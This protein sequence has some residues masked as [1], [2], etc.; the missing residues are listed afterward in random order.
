MDGLE[1]RLKQGSQAQETQA[2]RRVIKNARATLAFA[3]ALLGLFG[4]GQIARAQDFGPG[5][6]KVQNVQIN[7]SFAHSLIIHWDAPVNS[8]LPGINAY[9][10]GWASGGSALQ[11]KLVTVSG[12]GNGGIFQIQPLIQNQVYT[13]SITPMDALGNLGKTLQIPGV[14]A[15]GTY[16]ANLRQVTGN[17]AAGFLYLPESDPVNGRVNPLKINVDAYNVYSGEENSVHFGHSGVAVNN[18]QHWHMIAND[19]GSGSITCRVKGAIPLADGGV[20]NLIWDCDS[21]PF[22]RQTWYIVLTPNKME[23]FL[24]LPNN[25]DDQQTGNWPAEQVQIKFNGAMARVRRISGGSVISSVVFDWRKA[26]A[27]NVRQVMQIALSQQ[28]L[29]CYAD[30]DYN[31]AMQLRG[32]FPTDLSGWK[33]CYAYFTYGSYNNRKFDQVQGVSATGQPM[34]EFEGGTMHWGNV[35]FTTPPGQSPPAELSYFLYG[36][37]KARSM[38]AQPDVSQPLTVTIP[39]AIPPD[40]VARELVFTDR[41]GCIPCLSGRNKLQLTVNGVLLPNKKEAEAWSDYPTYRW[42]IPAGVLKRGANS[43]VFGQTGIPDPIGIS[44]LHIDIHVPAG[45][46]AIAAYTPPPAHPVLEAMPDHTVLEGWT[47][48]NVFA[49][50]PLTLMSGRTFVPVTVF[51]AWTAHLA[52]NAVPFDSVW[53]ELD[54]KTI[55]TQDTNASGVGSL[56]YGNGFWLDTKQTTD[57]YHSLVVKAHSKSGSMGVSNGSNP[58]NYDPNYKVMISNSAPNKNAPVIQ[59]VQIVDVAKNAATVLK[60]GDS[61]FTRRYQTYNWSLDVVTP[62][63]LTKVEIW[64]MGAN[65]SP[66]LFRAYNP[67]L[68]GMTKQTAGGT[69]YTFADGQTLYD[70]WPF[71]GKGQDRFTVIVSDVFGNQSS[72]AYSWSLVPPPA[73]PDPTK[74][75]VIPTIKS[76]GSDPV[77]VHKGWACLLSWNTSGAASVALDN[78]IGAVAAIGTV[79]ATPTKTTT[80]TLTALSAK[81][82]VTKLITV[83]VL[84]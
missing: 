69:Q 4:V 64:L 20:R 68:P 39:D 84:P 11:S 71:D 82:T 17:G 79:C 35:A 13:I 67:T 81:G 51:S 70:W 43:I 34:H 29:Q 38:N 42:Q 8:G 66:W 14:S 2:L 52:G 36:D 22:A 53:A 40:A 25:G 47:I 18:Q 32:S 12:A 49:T 78:G 26:I 15:K 23:Q 16:E 77:V 60:P 50:L 65:G 74:T 57:G 5:P 19:Y 21:G 3:L 10:V 7:D 46:A 48:P 73:A 1:V 45:S 80:Y 41:N 31:A 27:F 83:V 62:N 37:L 59:N 56:Y 63:L 30:V 55:W 75:A 61:Y 72:Y 24:L 33:S 44:N 6:A 58:Y 54:G 76:F 28:G 9:S